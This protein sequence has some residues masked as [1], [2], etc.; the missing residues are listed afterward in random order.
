MPRLLTV[1]RHDARSDFRFD[2]HAAVDHEIGAENSHWNAAEC[3][4]IR[5]FAATFDSYFT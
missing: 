2:E 5:H 3:N 1:R 4:L